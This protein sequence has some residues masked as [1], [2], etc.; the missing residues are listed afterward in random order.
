MQGSAGPQVA[1][2]V[3]SPRGWTAFVVALA[4]VAGNWGAH[5]SRLAPDLAPL[6][7]GWGIT[8]V[9]KDGAH[10]LNQV[11]GIMPFI[12]DTVQFEPATAPIDAANIPDGTR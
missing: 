8:S 2:V 11:N 9:H 7:R 6:H 5:P 1:E 12:G 3:M 4:L 10:D